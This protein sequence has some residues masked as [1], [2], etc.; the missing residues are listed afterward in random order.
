M[1]SQI[2]WFLILLLVFLKEWMV[3]QLPY[4]PSVCRVLLKALV[5]KV[6]SFTWDIHI[7]RNLDLVFYYFYQLFLFSNLKWVLPHHHFI[8][9]DTQGPN[10]Y[11]LVILLA[12]QYLWTYVKRSTTESGPQLVVLMYAPSKIAQ[13]NYVL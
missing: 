4:N 9:H 1:V 12:P 13:L 11:F 8:H 6:S 5:Q 10:I 2:E 3:H 7:W